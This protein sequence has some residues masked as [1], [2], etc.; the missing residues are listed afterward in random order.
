MVFTGR[1]VSHNGGHVYEA[2]IQVDEDWVRIW[3]GHK[4]F[5]A[6]SVGDLKCERVTVFRFHL[7]LDGV[8]HTFSPDDPAAFAESLKAVVDLRPQ[9]R[10]GLGERVRAAKAERDAARAASE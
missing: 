5:G 7:H 3:S 8:V 1:L 4:R 6:W 2:N 10:F 9:A